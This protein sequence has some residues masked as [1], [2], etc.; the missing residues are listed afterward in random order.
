MIVVSVVKVERDSKNDLDILLTYYEIVN[1][2][3]EILHRE[4]EKNTLFM[5]WVEVI[6]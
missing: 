5:Y 1:K 2:G 3:L 6:F 4:D